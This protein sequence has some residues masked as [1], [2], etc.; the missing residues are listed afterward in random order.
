[1]HQFRVLCAGRQ[2]QG[3]VR[4][5]TERGFGVELASDGQSIAAQL[6]ANGLAKASGQQEPAAAAQ[7]SAA[8]AGEMHI[9]RQDL[10]LLS[11]DGGSRLIANRLLRVSYFCGFFLKRFCTFLS[12]DLNYTTGL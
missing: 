3:R 6:V 7:G 2:L 5:I 8:D 10:L 9:F 11:D 1:M 4:S 12:Y